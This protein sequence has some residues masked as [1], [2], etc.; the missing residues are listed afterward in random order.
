MPM[1]PIPWCVGWPTV[2]RPERKCAHFCSGWCI[3]GCLAGALW[4]GWDWSKKTSSSMSLSIVRGIHRWPTNQPHPS[5][6]TP[7]R[8][9]TMHPPQQK[10]AHFSSGR[11]TAGHP[12]GAL[13]DP[14]NIFRVTGPL[15]GEFTGHRWIP[16]SMVSEV[17]LMFSLICALN[18]R[19]SRQSW[20]W[21]LETPSS[22][23]WHHCNVAFW[24]ITAALYS[25]RLPRSALIPVVVCGGW[26]GFVG[27]LPLNQLCLILL[28]LI[29]Y[30]LPLQWRYNER[31][32]VI[33]H[34]RIGSLLNRLVRRRSNKT[35]KLRDIGLSLAKT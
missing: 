5:H 34:R 32:G 29:S 35:S 30:F 6:C 20:S 10:C 12:T 11:C 18:K 31:D 21:W 8:H 24:W 1:S 7:A 15:C 4:D 16:L 17:E 26:W 33:N 3:V 27:G 9:P 19:L 28:Y 2:R 14:R 25:V 23:L 22:S 13:R